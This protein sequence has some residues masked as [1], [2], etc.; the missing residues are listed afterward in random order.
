MRTFFLCSILAA[1]CL[2]C[3]SDPTPQE[4]ITKL[5]LEWDQATMDVTDAVN[6]V[7][8]AQETANETATALLEAEALAGDQGSEQ[9]ELLETLQAQSETL[10]EY[11]QAAFEFVNQWQA[12]AERLDQLKTA[13]EKGEMSTEANAQIGSI[14]EMIQTGQAKAKEWNKA[15][16]DALMAVDSAR[17]VLQ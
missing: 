7:A 15:A 8:E 5:A 14:R 12:G 1:C 11:S 3:S 10:A 17:L 2:A 9:Q 16:E 4:D 6:Q 13:A